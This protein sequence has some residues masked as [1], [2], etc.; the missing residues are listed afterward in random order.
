VT[1]TPTVFLNGRQL[2][3]WQDYA[4]VRAAIQEAGGA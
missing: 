3:N 1:G 4:S 2:R